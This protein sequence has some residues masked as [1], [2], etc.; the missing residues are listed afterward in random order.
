VVSEKTTL[1]TVEWQRERPNELSNIPGSRFLDLSKNMTELSF[2]E[3]LS[4]GDYDP[5]WFGNGPSV[6]IG[7]V[8]FT[9]SLSQGFVESVNVNFTDGYL[10]AA[11][12]FYRDTAPPNGSGIQLVNWLRTRSSA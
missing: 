2:R 7:I 8:N 5:N 1:E 4:L 3:V 6:Y 9:V 10:P 12:T 11:A